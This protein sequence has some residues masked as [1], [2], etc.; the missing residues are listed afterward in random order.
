MSKHTPGPWS[1]SETGPKY[2]I[3]AGNGGASN[4]HIAMVS[5][6]QQ[7]TNDH[8]ENLANARIIAAAPELLEVCEEAL[9]LFERMRMATD[10]TALK[11]YRLI[12]KING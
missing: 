7:F 12:N 2:S 10:D 8:A 3:N 6:Y 4:K 1:I 9:G 5:C 11:L